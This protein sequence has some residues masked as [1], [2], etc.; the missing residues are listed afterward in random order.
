MTAKGDGEIRRGAMAA[1]ASDRLI[2][3]NYLKR[4]E[5]LFA[6]QRCQTVEEVRPFVAGKLSISVSAAEFIRRMR[7]QI[8]P[9]W[10]KERIVL[11][12]IEAAQAELRAI[13]HEIEVAR[14]IG[15]GNGDGKLIAARARATA[16]VDLLDSVATESSAKGARA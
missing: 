12:F 13:E 5:D 10:L 14:Q 11:L 1:A 16:L 3:S 15:L 6:R 4:A 9:S 2:A 8:V 7:R